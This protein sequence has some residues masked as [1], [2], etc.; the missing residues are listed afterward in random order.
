INSELVSDTAGASLKVGPA[1]LAVLALLLWA[2][3]R[4]RTAPLYLVAVSALV[5]AAA[6]GLT[7][8]AFQVWLNQ[9][10]L[11]FF[12]PIATAVLLLGLGCDYNV[13]LVGR[14]WREAD[15]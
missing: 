11:S 12:V 7:V 9:G 8:Y 4:S 13:F 6:L 14:I 3:L 2:L 1:A 15:R 5:V 10:Q